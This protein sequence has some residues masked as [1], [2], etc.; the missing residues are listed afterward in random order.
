MTKIISWS[1]K[2]LNHVKLILG[3]EDIY[4]TLRSVLQHLND[5]NIIEMSYNVD[6]ENIFILA[7]AIY[8]LTGNDRWTPRYLREILENLAYKEY[9]T[10]EELIFGSDAILNNLSASLA[11]YFNEDL[12]DLLEYSFHLAKSNIMMHNMDETVSRNT[13]ACW[14]GQCIIAPI[15]TSLYYFIENDELDSTEEICHS[16]RNSHDLYNILYTS[17]ASC[18]PGFSTSRNI[19]HQNITS[20]FQDEKPQIYHS[21]IFQET[22]TDQ[23]NSKIQEMTKQLKLYKQ[24]EV[25]YI[26]DLKVL[27]QQGSAYEMKLKE[28]HTTI[29][30][31][32]H[33]DSEIEEAD[34]MIAIKD[35]EIKI[36]RDNLFLCERKIKDQSIIL[37]ENNHDLDVLKKR[38]RKT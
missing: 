17:L 5:D 19:F 35:S 30:D 13:I 21:N 10:Y 4:V 6:Y 36:L 25:Q 37:D 11:S 26:D 7:M 18:S 23:F 22:L 16:I 38:S 3:E 2:I 24:N 1:R 14:I 20:M 8:D 9:Y 31:M 15:A 29:E 33:G 32:K 12:V 34:K 27:V 28:C